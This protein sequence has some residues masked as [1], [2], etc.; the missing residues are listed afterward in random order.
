MLRFARKLTGYRSLGRLIFFTL[1]S[2]VT[3]IS[4]GQDT[5]LLYLN[6]PIQSHAVFKGDVWVTAGTDALKYSQTRNEFISY[7]KGLDSSFVF[8]LFTDSVFLYV[9]N[10]RRLKRLDEQTGVWTEMSPPSI[11]ESS[12]EFWIIGGDSS[13]LFTGEFGGGLYYSRNHGI[14]WLRHSLS[15]STRVFN[16]IEKFGGYWYIGSNNSRL[17]RLSNN[18]RLSV[19]RVS[20]FDPVRNTRSGVGQLLKVKNRL[21]LVNISD[22]VYWTVD[23]ETWT[24]HFTHVKWSRARRVEYKPEVGLVMC[25]SED[26]QARIIDKTGE[27]RLFSNPRLKT[28][29]LG[30]EEPIKYYFSCGKIELTSGPSAVEIVRP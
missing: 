16:C 11:D 27:I 19:D 2:V 24:V 20:S 26:Q 23:G 9:L 5:T 15:D 29:F 22:G 30:T 28:K 13:V 4:S 25:Y 7:S 10:G 21:Y 18:E 1:F 8:D 14:S 6:A 12:P 17:Y 3:T